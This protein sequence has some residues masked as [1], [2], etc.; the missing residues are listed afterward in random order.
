MDKTTTTRRSFLKTGAIVSGQIRP[1][2][3]NERYFALLRV[4]AI[5]FEDPD[6]LSE[7]VCFVSSGISARTEDSSSCIALTMAVFTL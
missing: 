1:P 5:N 7:K 2:K 4:E 3:E 6:K